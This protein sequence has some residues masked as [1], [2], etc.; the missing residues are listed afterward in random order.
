MWR[1]KEFSYLF[2]AEGA[3]RWFIDMSKL[4]SQVNDIKHDIAN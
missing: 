3:L 1:I 4:Q 2:K